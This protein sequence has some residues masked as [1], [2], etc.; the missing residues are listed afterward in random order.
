MTTP[1]IDAS[2]FLSKVWRLARPYWFS[3]GRWRARLLLAAVVLLSLGI[4][5]VLVL[6]NEWQ[7][8]FYN[9]LEQRNYPD[10]S[11]LLVRFTILA[12]LFIIASVYRLYLRQMLEMRW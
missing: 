10:F 12:A 5:Y 11:A 9:A 4:V 7:R 2:P 6:L 1:P 3:E 8:L